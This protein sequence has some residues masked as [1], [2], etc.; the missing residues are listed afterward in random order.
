MDGGSGGARGPWGK[1]PRV[2]AA[3]GCDAVP[4]YPRCS[5][6]SWRQAEPA[7]PDGLPGVQGALL[8][9]VWSPVPAPARSARA[10]GP[11][12]E[13]AGP[14]A[15]P[16]PSRHIPCPS[17]GST[18]GQ[19]SALHRGHC[20]QGELQR[21]GAGW[22][23][24]PGGRRLSLGREQGLGRGLETPV[25]PPPPSQ[26]GAPVP[27]PGAG[28]ALAGLPLPRPPPRHPHSPQALGARA[29]VGGRRAR[30]APGAQR[31]LCRLT[32][33]GRAE[34]LPPGASPF[35]GPLRAPASFSGHLLSAPVT[36]Q[37]VR[38]AHL[39][40]SSKTK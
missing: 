18:P 13:L 10:R 14:G 39:R 31:P 38:A 23:V 16:L 4:E 5:R 2:A 9:A 1:C 12:V 8:G 22:P 11:C 40:G 3:A 29:G 6:G 21:G 24:V 19:S 25:P 26:R 28:P 34:H 32:G 17:R 7:V 30:A 20:S 27:E 33:W 37:R 36:L 15:G 35:A